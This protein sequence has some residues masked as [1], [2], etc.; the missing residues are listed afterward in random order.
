MEERKALRII[1]APPQ[2]YL[3]AESVLR[4]E[5]NK[6][7][8]AVGLVFPNFVSEQRAVFCNS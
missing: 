7:P 5:R 8:H 2:P 1:C 4:V 3:A 6:M